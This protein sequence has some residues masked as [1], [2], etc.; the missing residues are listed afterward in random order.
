VRRA[1]RLFEIIQLLRSAKGP[2][3][4]RQMADALE[5]TPRTIYRDIAALQAARVPVEGSAGVGYVMRRGYDLPPLMFTDEEIEA[6]SVGLR[7]LHR[8]GDIALLAAAGRVADKIA[9]V[10]PGSGRASLEEPV[11]F[12]S[13]WGVDPPGNVDVGTLRAAIREQRRLRLLY[14]D[15]DGRQSLRTVCPIALTYHVEVAVLAAWCELRQDFRH[16]RLDRIHRIDE[17]PGPFF[18]PGRELRAEW[19]A[20]LEA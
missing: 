20:R 1:D 11:L 17:E 10:L 3:T 4:A 19:R 15:Q 16:F 13:T 12:A 2:T 9:E 18:R 6:I 5:V 7:L 14:R 8:T